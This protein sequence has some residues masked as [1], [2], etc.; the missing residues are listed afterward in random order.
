MQ[1]KV[2]ELEIE[3]EDLLPLMVKTLKG[4]KTIFML[5]LSSSYVLVSPPYACW[6]D[7]DESGKKTTTW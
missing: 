6:C 2:R 3:D 4:K 5:E 7:G 1:S